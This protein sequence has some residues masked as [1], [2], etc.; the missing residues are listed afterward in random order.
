MAHSKSLHSSYTA[1]QAFQM[2]LT[3]DTGGEEE[4]DAEDIDEDE[5]YGNVA[6]KVTDN[7][8]VTEELHVYGNGS[9][10]EGEFE[11]L[12]EGGSSESEDDEVITKESHLFFL[13]IYMYQ[14]L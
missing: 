12:I 4:S 7:S 9:D 11:I 6:V 5:D 13:S 8:D 10:V 1:E 14:Y 3:N 2:L